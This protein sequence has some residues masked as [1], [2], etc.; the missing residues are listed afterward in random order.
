MAFDKQSTTRLFVGLSSFEAIAMFRRGLFYCYLSIYLRNFLGLSVTETTLFATIPMILNSLFQ[1]FVWGQ[2]SDRFQLRRT[3]IIVGEILGGVGTLAV[4]YLHRQ[5]GYPIAAGYVIIG[6]LAAIEAFWSMSNVGWSALISDIYREEERTAVQGRLASIGGLG[7][8]AGVWIGGLLYDGFKGHYAGWGF[9]EGVLFF[10]AAGAM[11]ISTIPMFF[12]PEGGVDRKAAAFQSAEGKESGGKPSVFTIFLIA[13]VF[14][15]FGRNAIA[16]IL[17]QYL[18]LAA[19]FAVSSRSLSHIVNTQSV[20]TIL[21]G[22]A[23]GWLGRRLGNGRALCLGALGASFSLVLIAAAEHLP[24]VY[25]SFF[26]RGWADVVIIASS[27][28]FASTLIPP[29]KRAKL[30]GVFNATLFL[31]WGLAGTFIAGPVIDL[32][33][34][35]GAGEIFAYRMAFLSA[36]ALALTG[37]FIQAT[38]VYRIIPGRSEDAAT[39]PMATKSS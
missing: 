39:H 9:Q 2:L 6:G 16:V 11:F 14:I 18:T 3:L 31:S 5:A 28:A 10:V 24:L 34:S 27:Y 7:Q 35:A 30:F 8:I 12:M 23:A 37:L 1:T 22:L 36:L 21:T 13:M 25:L 32:F 29:E 15:N 17:P 19:G 26:L 4:W 38:L 33:I 20:A